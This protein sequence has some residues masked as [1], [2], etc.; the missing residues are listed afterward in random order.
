MFT[1]EFNPKPSDLSEGK[2]FE[3]SDEYLLPDLDSFPEE[4]REIALKKTA[5]VIIIRDHLE[6]KGWTSKNLTPLIDRFYEEDLPFK[7]PGWLAVQRWQK[8]LWLADW[9]PIALIEKHHKK[10]N[11]DKKV[12]DEEFFNEA[13]EGYMKAE[14]PTVMSTY[15]RYETA[16]V[17]ANKK[18][19]Y[20]GKP[21]SEWAFYKRVEALSSYE[22][23]VKRFGKHKADMKFGYKGAIPKPNRPLER[24]EIDHTPLDLILL[25]DE[26][27]YPIG[28]PYLTLL[29]DVF[30][31]CIIGY[32]L[33]FRTPSYVS[34][35]KAICHTMLP[36]QLLDP[37]GRDLWEC[38]G[39]IENLVVD[40]AAEFWSES[41]DQFCLE[42]GINVHFNKPG[43]PWL[44]PF[45]ERK[46]G[47]IQKLMIDELEGKTFSNSIERGDYNAVKGAT[48]TFSTFVRAFE[49]WISEYYNWRPNQSKTHVPML[50]WRE[51]VKKLPPVEV[52]SIERINLPKLCGMKGLKTL[53]PSG[54]TIDYLRYD[55]RELADYRK[56]FQREKK[57]K[58]MTKLDVDDIGRIY[59]YLPEYER[60]L[61][62]PCV[63]FKYASGLS[64]EHHQVIKAYK[65]K[66]NKLYGKS[67]LDFAEA[68]EHVS[69]I[70]SEAKEAAKKTKAKNKK[71]G[72]MKR[73]AQYEGISSD[74][75]RKGGKKSQS[76][77]K[78]VDNK[79]KSAEQENLLDQLEKLWDKQ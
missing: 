78:S 62:V 45:V 79:V 55:S 48:Y 67:G 3:E 57:R 38:H 32:F 51:G 76:S 19:I 36:K 69:E 70:F 11:R 1:D 33:S 2:E 15:R 17:L 66:H 58:L 37:G 63:D 29:I 40:N 43:E 42:A 10:G 61:E 71:I 16:I 60:Y 20:S 22:I 68:Q 25:D 21:I 12:N 50:V 26:T 52:S 56:Q 35:A 46:F 14:R 72:G 24:V 54:I 7:K 49:Y 4:Q 9:N 27:L 34:V 23:T 59:V 31:K 47:V 28:R 41:L 18:G 5:L 64:Y 65:R 30:S 13:I 77:A 53:Q 8:K 73:V 44:K 6:G 75:V 74:S 39:K